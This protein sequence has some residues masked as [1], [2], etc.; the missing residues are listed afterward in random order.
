M[1]ERHESAA[2]RAP[3]NGFVWLIRVHDHIWNDGGWP[4][5]LRVKIC[6]E[7]QALWIVNL[8]GAAREEQE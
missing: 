8:W 1:S 4:V 7:L 2:V 6:Q 5:Y 3:Q